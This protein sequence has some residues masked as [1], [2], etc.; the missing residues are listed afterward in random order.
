MVI[1]DRVYKWGF[2]YLVYSFDVLISWIH[3]LSL[4]SWFCHFRMLVW[5]FTTLFFCYIFW[6]S[7][8]DTWVLHVHTTWLYLNTRLGSFL[9]PLDLHV[10]IFRIWLKWSPP[11]KIKP[12]R[13][14]TSCSSSGSWLSFW[15]ADFAWA[16]EHSFCFVHI[17]NL[18]F[19]PPG[20]VI[21]CNIISHLVI[22]L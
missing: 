2:P 3:R 13:R 12:W 19:A 9:T 18:T 5:L 7:F 22:T 21:C 16:C 14:P 20:N 1:W 8:I 17:V 15:L 4:C 11:P 6:F 10:Q